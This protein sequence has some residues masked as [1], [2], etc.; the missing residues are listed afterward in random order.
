MAT[1][2][3]LACKGYDVTVFEKNAYPGGKLSELK[4][5]DYRFDKGPSLLT[6][7]ALIDELQQLSG[8]SE[9]FK[10]KR[11]H[12]INT[13]FYSD[14]T[15]LKAKSSASE[16]AEE[17][18]EKLGEDRHA[19]MSYLNKCN[20]FFDTTFDIFLNQ[21][22]GKLSG[23]LNMKTLKGIWRAPRLGLFQSMH[24]Q[25]RRAFKNKK[26][27]QLF[28]RY[29]TYNGSNPYCA[30]A[31]LNQ[32]QHLELGIGAYIP[33]NG[34]HDITTYLHRMA[35][36]AGVSFRF[37][38]NVEEIRINEKRCIGIVSNSHFHAGK[39]IVCNGDIH[40]VYSK[41]LPA[42][43]YPKKL[44][45]Q[46]KSSSAYVFYWGISKSFDELGLHNILFSDNYEGEFQHLFSSDTSYEDPTV[47]I[48]ISSKVCPKDAPSGHENWFVMVNVPHN[49]SQR[50]VHYGKTIRQNV[51]KKINEILKT[52]IESFIVKEAT[53]D[54]YQIETETSSFGGSLYGNASNN[55]FS[56]F[57]RH[58]N[59]HTDIEG[60]YF[61]GG[62]VHPGGGIPLC[63]LGAK[64][65]S[66]L[67][68]K[69][70]A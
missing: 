22:L 66:A 31:L 43:Y 61:V 51:I 47:Y 19:V 42:S 49:A 44:L 48:N 63:L 30:P 69:D 10:Y 25:N 58:H 12:T 50:K 17:L 3:R 8:F 24:E 59:Y 55:R 26:T 29:A 27:V 14:G 6:L 46:P 11:L 39:L 5:D 4:L 2:I 35:V 15:V 28:D 64:I 23:F 54:P 65:T 32:I 34:M 37:N 52:N 9:K 53:L 33:D 21:S 45:N 7:P 18:S 16:L 60:L 41:L 1:S 68:S 40:H 38:E 57:L 13:L 36:F 56:A 70:D 67:I 62:S 20:F